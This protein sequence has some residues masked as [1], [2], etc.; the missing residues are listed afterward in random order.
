MMS[1]GAEQARLKTVTFPLCLL[2]Q[3]WPTF[4]T[5]GFVSG[6]LDLWQVRT[7]EWCDMLMCN[8]ASEDWC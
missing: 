4:F 5:E 1:Y 7:S 2:Q 6:G 8:L 3:P